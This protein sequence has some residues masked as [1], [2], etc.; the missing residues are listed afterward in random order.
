[1]ARSIAL[2]AHSSRSDIYSS[3]LSFKKYM[4]AAGIEV[5]DARAHADLSRTELI[6]VFGGDGTILWAAERAR[7]L[8]KP[9]LGI[10]Y[11]HVGFLAE[12]DRDSLRNVAD[13]IIAR[14]WSV[15][16]RMTVDLTVEYPTG[17]T[18]CGWAL[19]EAAIAKA[20]PSRMIGVDVAV[21]GHGVSS[22][23]TDGILIST[24]TGS[25]GYNFSAGGPIVW[26]DVQAMVLVPVAAHALFTRPMVVAPNSVLTVRISEDTAAVTC[27][28]RRTLPLARGSVLSVTRGSENVRLARLNDAPFSERLVAK[29]QLPVTGWRVQGGDES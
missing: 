2:I 3:I 11:G 21:D 25:T 12:V 1:M 13:A 22:F 9:I 17:K 28:G 18:V 8:R 4:K 14:E 23:K 19:N 29:F 6:A 20:P 26:P 24:P 7:G 10:N 16:E 27:D 5:V 15:D